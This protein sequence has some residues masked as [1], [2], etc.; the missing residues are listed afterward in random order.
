AAQ[1]TVMP[2]TQ[3]VTGNDDARQ[4]AGA[5]A[6]RDGVNDRFYRRLQSVTVRRGRRNLG[7]FAVDRHIRTIGRERH[8]CR[9]TVIK[10]RSKTVIKS[11]SNQ[12]FSLGDTIFPAS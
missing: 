8:V 3:P 2:F 12:A 5:L 1:Q 4:D 6:C 9:S 11:R 10:S 7:W